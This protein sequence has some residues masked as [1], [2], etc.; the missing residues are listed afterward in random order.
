VVVAALA[1]A[2]L[3][4]VLASPFRQIGVANGLG[5]KV[6]L[7]TPDG[8]QLWSPFVD[9]PDAFTNIGSF[10]R[11]YDVPYIFFSRNDCELLDWDYINDVLGPVPVLPTD[12]T[13]H[14]DMIIG[15]GGSFRTGF[16]GAFWSEATG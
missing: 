7:P 11:C 12:M 13:D 16:V 9:G 15:R 3:Q 14:G 4:P 5:A 10:R 2:T 1:A 8:V 6:V